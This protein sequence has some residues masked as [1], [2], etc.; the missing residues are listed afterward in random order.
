MAS[1]PLAAGDSELP[2]WRSTLRWAAPAAYLVALALAIAF[3]G[4]PT[5]RDALFLWILLGLVAASLT[6]GHLRV[7]SLILEWLPF[8]AILFAYDLLRGSADSIF[9]AHVEPQLRADELMFGGTAPT[10][11]L[12][13]HLWHG[14]G[15]LGWIDWFA[16][17]VYLTHF[18]GTLLVA[19]GLWLA[20]SRL[21]R[22][23]V[24]T[25]A[26]LAAAGF[27]TYALFPAAPPWLASQEGALEP[28]ERIVRFVSSAAPLDF[29][30]SVWEHGARYANDVAAV[31][32]LHAAYAL[33]I[34]IFLWPLASRWW[35]IPLAAYPVA[36]GFALVYTAEHYVVDVLLGWLYAAAATMA[37]LAAARRLAWRRDRGQ[38]PSRV[39]RAFAPT[40]AA[41]TADGTGANLREPVNPRPPSSGSDPRR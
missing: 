20:G 34:T 38:T 22:P 23:Y 12:Q 11:W 17:A 35:R 15:D 24:A 16:W 19:A 7:R 9:A 26:L 13:Q 27:A 32:S 2:R 18:F 37:V 4:L 6:T 10:V 40:D 31:P 29:F 8:G 5:A 41:V 33:L 39:D 28:T 1:W 25:V 36:M 30:G 14:P 3:R 21:F